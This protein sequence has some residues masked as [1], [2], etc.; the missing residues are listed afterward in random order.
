M[1]GEPLQIDKYYTF[2]LDRVIVEA[3]ERGR[4]DM[5][6]YYY[7]LESRGFDEDHFL[8]DTD[9]PRENYGYLMKKALFTGQELADILNNLI[10]ARDR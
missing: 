6:D 9:E 3:E 5:A 7:D 8:Q 10:K 4:S 1:E 2:W